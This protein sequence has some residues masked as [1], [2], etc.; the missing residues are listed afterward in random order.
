MRELF[1]FNYQIECYVPAAKRVY[2]YFTL[3]L[4]QGQRFVGRM[5]VKVHRK[6]QQMR[7]IHLHIETDKLELLLKSLIKSLQNFM[8]FQRAE[9]LYV[10]QISHA[11]QHISRA[12][13]QCFKIALLQSI[14]G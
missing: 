13:L 14:N 8:L 7:I 3:P 10:E 9:T 5:D 2:G 1:D 12:S 11:D 4:L 6:Q